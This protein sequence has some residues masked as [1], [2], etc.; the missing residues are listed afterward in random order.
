MAVLVSGNG[1][2][3][4][5]RSRPE[6]ITKK[7]SSHSQRKGLERSPMKIFDPGEFWLAAV[8]I[9]SLGVLKAYTR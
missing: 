4:P 8:G 7:R 9:I 1:P 5:A 2:K 6:N 3:W